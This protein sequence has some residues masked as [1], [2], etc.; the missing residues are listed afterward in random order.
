MNATVSQ[1]Y[2]SLVS[3]GDKFVRNALTKLERAG[4][5]ATDIKDGKYR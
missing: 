4:F 5:V 1:Y 3:V 2:C